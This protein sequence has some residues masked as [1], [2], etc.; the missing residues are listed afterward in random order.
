MVLMGS[1]S[2][3]A[4]D[5]APAAAAPAASAATARPAAAPAEEPKQIEEAPALDAVVV[6]SR[7]R[8]EKLQDV[9]LS[10]SVVQGAELER[11]SAYGIESV[12]KRAANVSWNLGNQRTSSLS[13]RGVGKVGQTEAQDPSV[14]VIVDGVNYAYN[15]LT[16]S[17]DFTD[18]DAIEVTRG[19]QGTLLGKNTSVGNIIITTRRPSFT[20][21]ADYKLEFRPGGGV[22]AS[23]AVG[24]PV[25]DDLLAWRGSFSVNRGEGDI[26]NVY[27]R[28]I[29]YTNKDRVSGRV[30]FLYTPTPDFNARVA[31]DLQPRAGETTNGRSVSFANAHTYLDGTPIPA[32]TTSTEARLNRRWFKDIKSYTIENYYDP[33]TVNNDQQRPLVTGSRGQSAELNW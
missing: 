33:N 12:T 4:A 18:I 11:L 25:V 13:I 17:F 15:A 29:T 16:S 7:N 8:I 19:P 26:V 28:D 6:R 22:F 31:F 14:G 27:N 32:S 1:A 23:G 24:G 10:V 9:P 20:P 2:A 3:W 5:E 21:T 30:Q